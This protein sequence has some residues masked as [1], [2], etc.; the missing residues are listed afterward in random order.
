M[1]S[2]EKI[3]IIDLFS[4]LPKICQDNDLLLMCSHDQFVMFLLGHTKLR[5]RAMGQDYIYYI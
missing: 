5:C 1:I 2:A 4:I 3:V